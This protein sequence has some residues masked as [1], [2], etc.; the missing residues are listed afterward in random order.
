MKSSLTGGPLEIENR[1][2]Q[3]DAYR[4]I[5]DDQ[6]GMLRSVAD[7]YGAGNS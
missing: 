4:S 2:Q 3:F 7:Q 1:M 5:A 6:T